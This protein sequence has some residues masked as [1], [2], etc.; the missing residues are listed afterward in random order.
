VTGPIPPGVGAGFATGE[1]T[2]ALM[3]FDDDQRLND[4]YGSVT[5]DE[6]DHLLQIRAWDNGCFKAKDCRLQLV[7]E[8]PDHTLVRGPIMSN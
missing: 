2:S 4:A 8:T 6:R 1:I 7:G 3:V 5:V